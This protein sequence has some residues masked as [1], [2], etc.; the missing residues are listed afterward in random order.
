MILLVWWMGVA[1]PQDQCIQVIEFFSG[2]GRIAAL[3]KWV[4]YEAAAYDRD[5]AKAKCGRRS[6]MDLNS[7]AGLVLLGFS[8]VQYRSHYALQPR[9]QLEPTASCSV[10]VA[11][12]LALSLILRGEFGKLV[13]VLAVCCSSFCTA[14]RATG[15]RSLLT[16]LGDENVVSV[17]R[18][19]KLMSRTGVWL[20]VIGAIGCLSLQASWFVHAP[21]C[22]PYRSTLLMLVIVAAGGTILMENPSLSVIGLHDRWV[23]LVK[24]L[25]QHKIEAPCLH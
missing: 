21:K 18:S 20:N 22:Q 4:G 7:N 10:D 2:V 8:G 6:P 16:P 23:W 13:G 1:S 11:L 12:R 19:N 25:R 14:N 17:R 24:S 15:A 9:P 3:A 5:Y